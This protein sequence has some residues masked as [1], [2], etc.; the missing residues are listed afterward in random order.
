M[1]DA[2]EDDGE[3]NRQE[4]EDDLGFGPPIGRTLNTQ[5]IAEEAVAAEEAL[6][7]SVKR[8]MQDVLKRGV[9]EVE[10]RLGEEWCP[11]SPDRIAFIRE[12]LISGTD[13][14]TLQFDDIVH[15]VEIKG[16]EGLL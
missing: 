15:I 4:D 12:S 14:F 3:N 6:A 2:T 1:G 16:S 9:L 11:P 13:K 7:A 5:Q 8:E 10:I